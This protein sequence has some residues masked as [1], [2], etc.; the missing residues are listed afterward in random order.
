MKME[1]YL[2]AAAVSAVA[3]LLVILGL[4]ETVPIHFNY[5]GDV[6]WWGSRWFYVIFACIPLAELSSHILYKRYSRNPNVEKN[7]AYEEKV[8]ALTGLFLAAIGWFFLMQVRLGETKLNAS[9]A[10]LILTGVG[11]IL[12]YVSNFMAKIR[13][14]HTLGFRVFWT[15]NDETVW[16]KAHRVA[17][18]AGVIGG[19]VIVVCSLLGMAFVAW[20]AFAGLAFGIAILAGVPM[21]YA[22]NLYRELH[23]DEK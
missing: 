16:I 19:T 18:Y 6:D 14:N 13:P 8:V 21:V 20:I 2:A 7:A 22:R 11:L 23:P 9:W 1:V 17:G 10:C 5:A 4:P 3:M 15:L 12:I